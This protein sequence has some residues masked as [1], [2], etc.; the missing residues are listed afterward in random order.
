MAKQSADDQVQQLILLVKGKKDEIIKAE[1]PD[2]RTNCSF[3]FDPQTKPNERTNIQTVGDIATLVSMLAFLRAKERDYKE[4]AQLLG[5]S[6]KFNWMGYSVED[7]Q[8][9]LQNR[10]NKIQISK[11]KADLAALEARLDKLIS[12]EARREMEL[13]EITKILAGQ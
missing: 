5:V 6:D 10:I 12:P 9:D 13:A 7:W 8:A 2:W 11:K 3:A 1:K 4:A